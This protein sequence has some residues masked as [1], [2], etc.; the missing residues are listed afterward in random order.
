[1]EPPERSHN[2]VLLTYQPDFPQ[3]VFD[4]KDP[5][6]DL[7]EYRYKAEVDAYKAHL[8]ALDQQE[9]ATKAASVANDFAQ[10][11]AVFTAYVDVTKGQLDRAQARAEFVQTAAA[12]VGTLYTGVL[13][14]TVFG[15]GTPS[16]TTAATSAP[17]ATGGIGTAGIT[18][19]TAS[20]APP[21]P[22][23]KEQWA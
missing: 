3:P 19:T 20:Q 11:Q 4:L 17:A 23:A 2:A 18:N 13:A 5:Y 15:K 10:R 8:A 9:Q 1:M 12:A 14:F 22:P 6:H 16:G 7:L 21:A